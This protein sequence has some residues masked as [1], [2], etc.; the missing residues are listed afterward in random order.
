MTEKK[1]L[2]YIDVAKGIAMVL[3]LFG[4]CRYCPLQ[5]K[6]WLYSFHMPLFFS[7]SGLTF[8]IGKGSFK[9]FFVKKSKGFLIPYAMLS[10]A[11]WTLI[12]PSRIIQGGL[13]LGY[14]KALAGIAL[15]YRHTEYYFTMWFILALFIAELV[16]FFVVKL[17]ENK[18]LWQKNIIILLCIVLFP[19]LGFL[20]IRY[21]DGFIWSLDLA[22]F[23]F[24][25]LAFGYLIK[26]NT[27]L[28]KKVSKIYLIPIPLLINLATAYQNY[29]ES[30]YFVDLY[31]GKVGN[32]FYYTLASLSGTMFVLSLCYIIKKCA[33]LE[34]IGK[35]TLVF[36]AFQNSL[37]IPFSMKITEYLFKAFNLENNKAVMFVIVMAISIVLLSAMS[38]IINRY[39]PF[40]LGK[41]LSEKTR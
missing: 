2:S 41:K 28:F 20:I 11:M 15:G 24:A 16:L 27:D 23:A 6:V 19:A 21:V 3:V 10:L 14:L 30:G 13:E 12:Y 4:H 8:S 17:I 26:L 1:R 25:F 5:L 36:Y 32:I 34:Y 38:E 29:T 37:V 40:L 33:I 35:N 9:E 39:M 18:K 7:L 31:Y 22:P